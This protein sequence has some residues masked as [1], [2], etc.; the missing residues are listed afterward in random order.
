[1]NTPNDRYRGGP[2]AQCGT[3]PE[4]FGVRLCTG[5]FTPLAG[6]GPLLALRDPI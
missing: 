3:G 5:Y 4:A 1:M 6:T 2:R